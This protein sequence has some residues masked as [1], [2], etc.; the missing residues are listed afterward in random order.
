M[1]CSSAALAGAVAGAGVC[2]ADSEAAAANDKTARPSAER[3]AVRARLG[4]AAE[5]VA[6]GISGPEWTGDT[7]DGLNVGMAKYRDK[8][9]PIW[10]CGVGV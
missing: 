6:E 4:T 3:R 10:L 1:G 2:C 8:R 7:S 5:A 9:E